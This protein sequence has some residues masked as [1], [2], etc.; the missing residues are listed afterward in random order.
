MFF[1]L[2]TALFFPVAVLLLHPS[3]GQM[4]FVE[5]TFPD[6]THPLAGGGMG[7]EG[8]D[9]MSPQ[10]HRWGLCYGRAGLSGM[11]KWEAICQ[12]RS[13]WGQNMFWCFVTAPYP[14]SSC[15]LNQSWGGKP[16]E[17]WRNML[18][19]LQLLFGNIYSQPCSLPG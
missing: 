1:L 6:I 13:F 2:S 4:P 9:P 7:G 3:T 18:R 14:S 10:E 19:R 11:G 15:S 8:G 16:A 12:G 5:V 17:K